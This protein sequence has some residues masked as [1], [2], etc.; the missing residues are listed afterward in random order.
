MKPLQKLASIT[1]VDFVEKP[2]AGKEV[3]LSIEGFLSDPLWELKKEIIDMNI[4]ESKINIRIWRTRDPNLMAPQIVKD[5][6]KEIKITFP[7]AGKWFVQVN[8]KNL[9]ID[10]E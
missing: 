3:I 4:Q 7:H 1:E 6:R 9:E 10:V 5:Y 8:D 2:M